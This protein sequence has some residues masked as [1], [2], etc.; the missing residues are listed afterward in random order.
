MAFTPDGIAPPGIP[1]HVLGCSPP[2]H[3][4]VQNGLWGALLIESR[5]LVCTSSLV[6]FE[7]PISPNLS[8]KKCCFIFSL[9]FRN[10]STIKC[11]F[12]GSVIFRNDIL[13]N[14]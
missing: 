12:E 4:E 8:D 7:S 9:L 11:L 1:I 14:I 10:F 6:V 3:D 2:N 5:Q 13:F